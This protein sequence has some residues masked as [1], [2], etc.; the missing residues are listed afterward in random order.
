MSSK[1]PNVASLSEL[2]VKR[3]MDNKNEIN[4]K[5][6]QWEEKNPVMI[7]KEPPRKVE[8]DDK[9]QTMDQIKLENQRLARL[10]CG[11]S[12]DI[13]DLKSYNEPS[14]AYIYDPP[15]R[16]KS[17][18]REKLHKENLEQQRILNSRVHKDE[19]ARLYE[20]EDEVFAL[21]HSY[22]DRFSLTK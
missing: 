22:Q 4:G 14:L 12:E 20:R 1:V 21:L 18:L 5:I 6:K 2:K 9:R 16:T 10:Q 11:L 15:F 19:V 8:N 17:D 7:T 13:T 3:K